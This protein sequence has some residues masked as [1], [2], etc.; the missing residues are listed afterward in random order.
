[1]IKYVSKNTIIVHEAMI[2]S[3]LKLKKIEWM[4]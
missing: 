2:D 1:M 3:I 4:L